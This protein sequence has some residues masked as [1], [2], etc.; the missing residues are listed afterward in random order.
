MVS[1]DNCAGVG[2]E[3]GLECVPK[4]YT[5]IYLHSIHIVLMITCH[6]SSAYLFSSYV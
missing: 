4:W 1:R 3:G 5:I 2:G 6:V